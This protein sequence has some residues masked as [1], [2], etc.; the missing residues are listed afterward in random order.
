MTDHTKN[1]P[2]AEIRGLSGLKAVVWADKTDSGSTRYSTQLS[3]TYVK[4]GQYFDTSY[5]GPAELLQVAHLA[6]QAYEK[7]VE[8][9]KASR[10]EVAGEQEPA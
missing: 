9:R 3:R 1:R 6:A 2:A 8:L 4:E 7:I 10:E 5:F